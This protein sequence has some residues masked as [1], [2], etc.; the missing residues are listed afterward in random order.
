MGSKHSNTEKS[1]DATQNAVERVIHICLVSFLS[2]ILLQ[3]FGDDI[4][5]HAIFALMCS[6]SERPQCL[7]EVR[8]STSYWIHVMFSNA[9][10]DMLVGCRL[11]TIAIPVI[12]WQLIR[13]L[14]NRVR[15][16]EDNKNGCVALSMT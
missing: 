3:K 5:L 9:F 1:G 7:N 2:H 14:L 15:V 16:R 12:G 11:L 8:C 4:L 6:F 10:H 13:I